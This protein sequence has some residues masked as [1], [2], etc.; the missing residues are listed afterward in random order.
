MSERLKV[1]IHAQSV[2]AGYLEHAKGKTIE[3]I[4]FG[5]C[6]LGPDCHTSE[7][8]IFHFADGTDL[9]IDIQSNASDLADRY[10]GL[11]ARDF[12]ANLYAEFHPEGFSNK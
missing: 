6:E 1:T 4:E 5:T 10:A 8:I 3:D 2:T 12:D 9:S 7:R 11:K